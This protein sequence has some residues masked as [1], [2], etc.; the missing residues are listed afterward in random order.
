[1]SEEN[2][3]EPAEE[4]TSSLWNLPAETRTWSG[5]FSVSWFFQVSVSF[6]SSCHFKQTADLILFPST[7]AGLCH[8]VSPGP[9]PDL[10]Q[11]KYYLISRPEKWLEARKVCQDQHKD[12]ASV[13]DKKDLEDLA[14]LIGSGLVHIGLHREWGWTRTHADDHKE[15]EPVYWTLTNNQPANHRCGGIGSGGQWFSQRC[16][17]NLHFFCYNGETPTHTQS[18][19]TKT[20]ITFTT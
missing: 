15:G 1:M 19:A 20:D 9:N 10:P 11:R 8:S 7:S 5:G 17:S 12:L 18:A 6:S 2:V 4:G 14:A 3:C 13:R 16:W